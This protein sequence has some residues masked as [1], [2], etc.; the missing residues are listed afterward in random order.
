M[1]TTTLKLPADLKAR[2]APLAAAAGK[3]PH[4]WMVEA[5]QAQVALADLRQAFIHEARDSAADV[6]AGGPVFAMDEVAAYLR[7]SLAGRRMKRPAPVSE[8]T[9]KVGKRARQ[10][11]G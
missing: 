1:S 9:A 4:A 11:R 5:L 7:S 6:D 10:P 3:T 8:A 2:I